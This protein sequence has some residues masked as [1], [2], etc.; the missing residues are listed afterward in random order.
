LKPLRARYDRI[1]LYGSS[2]GAYAA[3]YYARDEHVLAF[4]PRIPIHPDYR[5]FGRSADLNNAP[6]VHDPLGYTPNAAIIYDPLNEWDRTFIEAEVLAPKK[7]FFPVYLSGHSSITYLGE[8]KVL[9]SIALNFIKS[10]SLPDMKALRS[11]RRL[12]PK[13]HIHLSDL[14]EARKRP[15]RAA[16]VVVDALERWPD[17]AEF[18]ARAQRFENTAADPPRQ[19]AQ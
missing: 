17:N 9:P 19:A 6:F 8:A 13:V 11:A 5:K 14:C 16:M 18:R 2:L 7:A 3:L 15:D 4:S 12:S 10:G 1:V